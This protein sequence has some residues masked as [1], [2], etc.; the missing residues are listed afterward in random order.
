MQLASN[1]GCSHSV[2]SKIRSDRV[3]DEA[4]GHHGQKTTSAVHAEGIYVDTVRNIYKSE[5]W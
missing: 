1:L 4:V 5:W 2:I 3:R